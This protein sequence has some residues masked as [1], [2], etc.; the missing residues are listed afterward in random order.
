MT[1]VVVDSAT[2]ERLPG[3]PTPRLIQEGRGEAYFVPSDLRPDFAG[4][5]YLRSDDTG[6]TSP[7]GA[8]KR[9]YIRSERD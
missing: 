4:V 7:D 5:W 8:Y 9:V 3:I 6:H 1:Y 2:G